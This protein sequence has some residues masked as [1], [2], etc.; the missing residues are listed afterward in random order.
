MSA[1]EWGLLVLAGVGAGLVG[2]VAGLASLI[3]Y[4]A[5][6]ATGVPP[7]TA[8]VTNTVALVMTGVGSVSASRPELRGQGR[9]FLPLAAASVLG[10]AAGA[11]LLLSTPPGAF[12]RIV[13]FLIAAAS[14]AILVQRPPREL[15]AEGAAAHAGGAGDPRWLPGVV[16]AIGVYG[17]YFG[18]AAGVLMLATLLLATGD[19]LPRSNALK[20][21]VLAVA[22]GVA[23]VGYVLLTDVAWS[24]CL[25]LA[26]G[27]FAGGLLGPRVVRRSP[28]AVLRRVI[29]VAGLGLA[30]HLG[31]QAFG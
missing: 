26:V 15:A 24:A 20:N 16:F 27:L 5:L 17:G 14:V 10:G 7:V 2:S 21:A 28:P 29:A 22:N 18:A 19:G 30:L 12:E 23:A 31:V 8:N 1:L 9:R 6:L 3:S 25:P 4:P 13:P 11:A